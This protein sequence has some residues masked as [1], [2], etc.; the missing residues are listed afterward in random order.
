MTDQQQQA[1]LAEMMRFVALDEADYGRFKTILAAVNRHAPAGLARLYQRISG[2][3]VSSL[4]RSREAMTHAQAKQMNHWR[5]L[6]SGRLDEAYCQRAD[7]IGRTHARIGLAPSWYIGGYA[8]VLEEMIPR[9]I[10][11]GFL[12]RLLMRRQARALAT[13]IKVAM[14]D[15]DVAL[16]AYQRIEEGKRVA[17]IEQLSAALSALAQGDFLARLDGLPAEYARIESDFDQM[18]RQIADTLSGVTAS[19]ASVNSGSNEINQASSD[20]AR[21]TEHQAAHLE[22][23]SAAMRAITM[24]IGE[25]ADAAAH[26]HKDVSDARATADRSGQ[27]V[28]DAITAMADIERSATDIADIVSLI[29]GI[30][31]QTNLLALNAGVEAAR[32]GDAGNGFAVV[33]SEV[34][35]L[36]QRSGEA[37]SRIKQLIDQSASQ[38]Q[39]G[40]A[41]V[42]SSGAGLEEIVAKVHAVAGRI[43]EISGSAAGQASNLAQVNAAVAEI[44]QMTQ[45]N[46]AMV[47]QSNAA[48]RSLASEATQLA[49]LVGRFRFESDA[50]RAPAR[51]HAAPRRRAA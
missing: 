1:D 6:F 2:S 50:P 22:E 14:V 11:G 23:T 16:S 3:S 21:R 19:A 8:V 37:A 35:A 30:A 20:L 44:D 33:A 5:A 9:M 25:T 17:V 47:E 49:D 43:E 45:Q 46:A 24:A 7:I 42:Q 10:G 39:R 13:F 18:R 32:A 34:R 15:M 12:G 48:A 26:V 4:F 41:L 36:A 51:H 40:V 27:V 38:V 31:F 28:R 29:D